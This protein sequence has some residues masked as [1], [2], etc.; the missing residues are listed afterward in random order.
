LCLD[1]FATGKEQGKYKQT[2]IAR[3]KGMPSDRFLS[4]EQGHK[5]S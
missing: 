1:A 4:L 3:Q 5:M 2:G